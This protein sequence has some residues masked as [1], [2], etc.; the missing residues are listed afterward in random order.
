MTTKLTP[1][2]LDDLDISYEEHVLVGK[3]ASLPRDWPE[4]SRIVAKLCAEIRASW[5]DNARLQAEVEALTR[6]IKAEQDGMLALRKR[7]GAHDH[8]TVAAWIGRL[9]LLTPAT[10]EQGE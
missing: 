6:D 5:A 3:A 1:E 9:A 10:Q 7:F 4:W 8:E 2:R